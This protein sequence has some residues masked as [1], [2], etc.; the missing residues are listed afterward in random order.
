MDKDVVTR[1]KNVHGVIR[2][3][4]YNKKYE[5]AQTPW[6][7]RY[8]EKMEWKRDLKTVARFRYDNEKKA[9]S[10]KKSG[11]DG[12]MENEIVGISLIVG[13]VGYRRSGWTRNKLLVE[14]GETYLSWLCT[15]I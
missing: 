13:Y 7:L 12:S 1:L 15:K 14:S 5:I 4:S 11:E 10:F 3:T 6:V 9:D 8:E 2:I